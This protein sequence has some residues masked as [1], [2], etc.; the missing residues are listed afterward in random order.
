MGIGINGISGMGEMGNWGDGRDVEGR[1]ER[2]EKK[3]RRE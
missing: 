2:E 1:C 3:R